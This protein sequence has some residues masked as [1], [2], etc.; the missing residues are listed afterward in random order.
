[1]STKD[2]PATGNYSFTLQCVEFCTAAMGT[3][4]I[5]ETKKTCLYGRRKQF[6]SVGRSARHGLPFSFDLPADCPGSDDIAL[7]GR[8]QW[9]LIVTAPVAGVDFSASFV[10]PVFREES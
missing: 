2:L 6:P 5:P 4:E 7:S 10:I 3:N 1:M 9:S 8:Y